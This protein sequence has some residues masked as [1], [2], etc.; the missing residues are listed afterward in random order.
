MK[1]EYTISEF[2]QKIGISKHTLRYYEK[3]GLIEPNRNA[4]NYRIYQ[5]IDFDWAV[6]VIK[7]KDTGLSLK[8]IKEYTYLR[9]QGAETITARK[10]LLLEHR[11]TIVADFNKVKSHLDLLDNKINFYAQLEKEQ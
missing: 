8:K 3:E 11:E 7:L 1:K 9:K 5:E 10:Q 4:Q 6:F 2:A